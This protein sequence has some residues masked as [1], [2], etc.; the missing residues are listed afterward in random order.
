MTKR[1]CNNPHDDGHMTMNEVINLAMKKFN[2]TREKVLSWYEKEN[3]SLKKARPRELVERGQ[4]NKIVELLD[5]R[6]SDRERNRK[7]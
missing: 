1:K 3:P 5:K 6:E 7:E 2:W 4:T